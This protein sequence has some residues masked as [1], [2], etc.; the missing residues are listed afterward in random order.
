MTIKIITLGKLKENLVRI[1]RYIRKIAFRD[2]SLF[3][4]SIVFSNLIYKSNFYSFQRQCAMKRFLK[5]FAGALFASSLLTPDASAVEKDVVQTLT[6]DSISTRRAVWKFP[7]DTEQ[8][9]K[10]L[11]YYTLKCDPRTTQDKF[12]CG[13]WDYDTYNR[14]YFN[15]GEMDSTLKTANR[16]KLG[17]T[18]PATIP[19]TTQSASNT[20][21]V[22]KLNSTINS[23]DTN[24]DYVVGGD[25]ESLTLQKATAQHIQL[26]YTEAELEAAGIKDDGI[27][28]IRLNTSQGTLKNAKISF[29][30]Y[31]KET[32]TTIQKYSLTEVYSGDL[33]LENDGWNYI[34]LSNEFSWTSGRGLIID[35]QY[36]SSDNDITFRSNTSDF[37]FQR[38]QKGKFISFDGDND[39]IITDINEELNSVQQFTYETWIKVDEWKNWAKVM[40]KE[41]KTIIELGDKDGSIYLQVR[42]GSN[43]HGYSTKAV[44]QG[45]WVHI[46]MVFDGT[47]TTNEE[48][49]KLYV[50]GEEESLTYSAAIPDRTIDIDFPF[51]IASRY[52]GQDMFSGSMDDIRVWTKAIDGQT[53]HDWYAKPLD[54]THPDFDN[55]ILN[56]DMESVDNYVIDDKSNANNDGT[57]LGP[58]ALEIPTSEDIYINEKQL[59]L[60]PAVGLVQGD[61]DVTTKGE[62]VTVNE[63]IKPIS[64]VEYKIEGH[65]PVIDNIKYVYPANLYT[66]SYDIDG[67]KKDSTL[68]EAEETLTNEK[69]TYYSEPFEKI[70][71]WEIGRFITPYGINLDL[72][73]EGFTWIYDVTDYAPFL[74]GDVEMQAGNNQE[75]IDVR[76][77]FI[78]GTPP[79]QVKSIIRPWGTQAGY[80]YGDLSDDEELSEVDVDLNPEASQWKVKTRIT[81]HGHNSNDGSFPHCCE[82]KDNT[83]K[84]LSN[85]KLAASWH[86]WRDDCALNPVYPQGGTWPGQ[87]EGWCPGDLVREHEFEFTEFVESHSLNIDYDLTKVPSSNPGMA[88]GQY[89][90]A[91]QVIEYGPNSFEVD[92]EIYDVYNPN[93]WPYFSRMNPICAN[94]TIVVRNNGIDNL[95]SLTIKYQVS[96]SNNIET[97]NWT[98]KIKPHEKEIITLPVK[99]EM[100]W[101]GDE[102]HKFL[103]NISEPNGTTDEY[104][105]NNS[106]ETAFELPDFYGEKIVFELKTNLRASEFSYKIEDNAGDPIVNRGFNYMTANATYR[107]TI[108]VNEACLTMKLEDKGQYGLSYWAVPG[109]G[110]GSLTIKDI[111]GKVLKVFNPDCGAGIHYSFRTGDIS[112]VQDPNLQALLS[113]TPVPANDNVTLK[114]AEPLG[115]AKMEITD[116]NGAVV[117][118]ES[119]LL[120]GDFEKQINLD[121]FANGTYYISITSDKAS[122]TKEFIVNK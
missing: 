49:L 100:F 112:L 68:I 50:N 37:A 102:E 117:L 22:L 76:F 108:R 19:Y 34:R 66:Y 85:G 86:I 60:R 120:N 92:A 7:D 6:F 25:T 78:K 106:Y 40:G 103:V 56:Y 114:I 121:N 62:I 107:D 83:H 93:N 105:E 111:D 9:R 41:I 84:L 72:G 51:A 116:L 70:D 77:E 96:G 18:A 28:L 75:L 64:I 71:V 122:F 58:A 63:P 115:N 24:N 12:D 36:E 98:G 46:A 26:L 89:R 35:I 101:I 11:M 67:N 17:R 54:N 47:G 52:N 27:Q 99:D 110:K 8:Y 81:G 119:L 53:I 38:Q 3:L 2:Y 91:C 69:L 1:S 43:S 88:D 73:P 14:L 113:V 44:Y 79:R 21:E 29:K 57:I 13:E 15:T 5:F 31:A 61:N 82:W 23:I 90:I 10:I 45:K 94:P 33:V 4:F 32:L 104:A 30:R 95:K 16:Y 39:F 80:S 59:A 87:R 48:K 65:S 118:S 74:K 42:N 109:Q 55:L 97:L 20:R